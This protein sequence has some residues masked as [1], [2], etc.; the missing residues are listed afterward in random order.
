VTNAHDL[1]GPQPPLLATDLWSA[2]IAAEDYPELGDLAGRFAA[3]VSRSDVDALLWHGRFGEER[4]RHRALAVLLV[5]SRMP[6]ALSEAQRKQLVNVALE[7]V[8][9]FYP[10]S[11]PGRVAFQIV[12]ESDRDALEPLV[13]SARDLDTMSPAV[14]RAVIR[15]LVVLKTAGAVE[16]LNEWSAREDELGDAARSGLERLGLVDPQ[17][18]EQA[19]ET[20]RRSHTTAALSRACRLYFQR[21]PERVPLATVLEKFGPP[22]GRDGTQYWYDV[23]DGETRLLL[24]GDAEHGLT[25]WKLMD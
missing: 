11:T 20:W 1:P 5:A 22:T 14:Q 24:E 13:L 4:E 15:D 21:L 3:N 18:V 6:D 17:A 19:F 9:A 23:V 10:R 2:L 12:F 25:G 16:R 7:A 8:R